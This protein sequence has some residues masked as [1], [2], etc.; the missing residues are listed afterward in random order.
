MKSNTLVAKVKLR[1]I[2][3]RT[4]ELILE[5]LRWILD[6]LEMILEQFGCLFEQLAVIFENRNFIQ[7]HDLIASSMIKCRYIT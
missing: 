7:L 3:I 6:E 5:Y 4:I 2:F 1:V